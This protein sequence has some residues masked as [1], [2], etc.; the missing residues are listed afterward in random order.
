MLIWSEE[1]STFTSWARLACVQ[2]SLTKSLTVD[3]VQTQRTFWS[4]HMSLSTR[5]IHGCFGSPFSFGTLICPLPVFP[6]S[7]DQGC[8]NVLPNW[9]NSA[10]FPSL[11]EPQPEALIFL[12]VLFQAAISFRVWP[13]GFQLGCGAPVWFPFSLFR[14]S[15]LFG[16]WQKSFQ[17]LPAFLTCHFFNRDRLRSLAGNP[18]RQSVSVRSLKLEDIEWGEQTLPPFPQLLRYEP[19]VCRAHMQKP[20]RNFWG[21]SLPKDTDS[22]SKV[23]NTFLR[24][25]TM[26]DWTTWRRM[27]TNLASVSTRIGGYLKR[28]V[29]VS[30]PSVF[31]GVS[32]LRPY[33]L[34]TW[35]AELGL[36]W[37]L[38]PG[39][40]L[41]F[42]FFRF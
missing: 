17:F 29:G 9:Q 10:S 2:Y 12:T 30:I 37:G 28:P 32:S 21:F 20:Q 34:G 1:N 13:P 36:P 8:P 3:V 38:L 35:V 15:M 4:S 33:D 25:K 14:S 39:P 19:L 7:V 42:F 24:V 26:S 6:I 22:Y 40:P 27:E 11:R 5:D 23:D 41:L 31:P 16:C 18:W